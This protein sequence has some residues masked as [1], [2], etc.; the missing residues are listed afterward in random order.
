LTTLLDIKN[1]TVLYKSQGIFQGEKNVY[2]VNNLS[3][4]LNEGEIFSIAGE[5]GCGKST[6]ANGRSKL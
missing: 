2:A 6:L 4:S 5:S 1:L 3:L